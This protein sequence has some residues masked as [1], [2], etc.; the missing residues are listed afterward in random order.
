MKAPLPVQWHKLRCV[1]F[2][3]DGTLYTQDK[4]RKRMLAALLGY[5]SI[6]PWLVQDLLILR[7]FRAER[8]K[9]AGYAGENLE[10]DQYAWV[11]QGRRYPVQRVRSVVDRWMFR[12]PLAYLGAC[13]YPGVSEFFAALRARGIIVGIYS[14]YPAQ[15]KLAALGLEADIVVSSTDADINRLKPDPRGLVYI[16]QQLGLAP[17]Q[18]LFVGDR[19]E[20]D[21]ACAAAAAMP[22]LIVDDQPFSDFTFYHALTYHLT[23]N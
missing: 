2:D 8:E 17:Q 18:C 19:P 15:E 13:R 4:L 1:I 5:Y 23:K 22:C 9:Q 10:A 21:G 12:H 7:Y 3:V 20:L 6:R 11:A 14:D 16:A